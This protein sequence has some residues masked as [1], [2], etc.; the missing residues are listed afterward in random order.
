M[1]AKKKAFSMEVFSE[2]F[3]LSAVSRRGAAAPRCS[4]GLLP[5]ALLLEIRFYLLAKDVPSATSN[6]ANG[7]LMT[8]SI[9]PHAQNPV[10]NFSCLTSGQERVCCP[11]VPARPVTALPGLC[12]LWLCKPLLLPARVSRTWEKG[13][14]PIADAFLIPGTRCLT[15]ISQFFF[16]H[17]AL[18][19][20]SQ[21]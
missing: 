11:L 1:Q 14:M 18:M 9:T 13:Q 10:V 20:K 5:E 12:R 8:V 16:L 6:F 3:P 17:L 21:L 2:R 15:L 19:K 4:R 7:A